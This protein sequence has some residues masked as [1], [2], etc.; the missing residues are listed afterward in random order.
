LAE[1]KGSPNYSGASKAVIDRQLSTIRKFCSKKLTKQR[2]V[3]V[4]T[5]FSFKFSKAF[6]ELGLLNPS[7]AFGADQL[8]FCSPVSLQL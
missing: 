3:F 7:L 1:K 8:P 5:R 2:K 6:I 4:W